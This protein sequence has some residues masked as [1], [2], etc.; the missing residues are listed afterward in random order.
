MRHTLRKL[1]WRPA[2]RAVTCL[3][4]GLLT[5]S[6]DNEVPVNMDHDGLPVA[7]CILNMDDSLQ[8]VRL[9]KSFFPENGYDTLE[10]LTLERWTEPV[11]IYIEEWRDPQQPVVHDFYPGGVI[12]QDTGYFADPSFSLYQS[13]F[14]PV[15]NVQ[16][17]LYLWFPERNYY[18]WATTTAVD[19][20]DIVNPR[21]VTGRK[22]TF[23]DTDDFVVQF[24]PPKNSGFHQFGFILTIEEHLASGFNLDHFDFGSQ[25]YEE[26]NGQMMVI[27]LNS[28]RFYRDLVDRYDT[29][30]GT[31]YRRVTGLEFVACTYGRELSLY[32]QL[33]NNGTQPWEIQSYSSFKNG[34]GL[35]SSR[36]FS[37]VTNL[38][39]SSLTYQLLTRD[40]RFKHMKFIQ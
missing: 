12:L 32:N 15:P 36:T 29:L 8:Q 19:R 10:H 7:W 25:V 40:Q 2:Y 37:R 5:L 3:F 13:D 4:M 20:L 22:I 1:F 35:F 16:Y 38:E 28:A 23:S 30:P 11:Q 21:P 24:R 18:T 34:F 27:Q 26:G 6:C 9:A 14:K 39:L 31:E 17:Y 33:Y